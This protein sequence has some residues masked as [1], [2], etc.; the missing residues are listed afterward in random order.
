MS[1]QKRKGKKIRVRPIEEHTTAAWANID[2]EDGIAKVN[3]PST[4]FVILARDRVN[5]NQKLGSVLARPG[6]SLFCFL[7]WGL[8]Q[9]AVGRQTPQGI[10]LGSAKKLLRLLWESSPQGRVAD[11]AQEEIPEGAGWIFGIKA[12]GVFP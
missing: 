7:G 5:H 4:D 8:R 9:A 1:A 2:R 3:I 6:H 12:E 10:L 11:L